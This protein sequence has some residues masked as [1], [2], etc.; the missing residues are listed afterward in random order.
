M[1]TLLR[2]ISTGAYFEGPGRWTP[3][4][5]SAFDF[6]MIDRALRFMQTWH[7]ENVEVAF[8]FESEVKTVPP[9]KIAVGYN[10]A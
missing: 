5:E 2:N 4:P 1:R 9:E 8:A 7:L 10:E 3:N 6:K